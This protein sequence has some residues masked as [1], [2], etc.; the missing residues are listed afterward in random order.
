MVVYIEYIFLD[1]I[2]INIF[3]LYTT[4]LVQRMKPNWLAIFGSG[5][6]GAI[7]SCLYPFLSFYNYIV[8]V[9]L[10]II[11][12][13][14][15]KKYKTIKSFFS[16]LITFYFI[17]F[18]LAG[19]VLMISSFNIINLENYYGIVQLFPFCI[20][21]SCTI[22]IILIKLCIKDFYKNRNLQKLLYDVLIETNGKKIKLKGYYDSGNQLYDPKTNKPMVI[23]SDSIYNKL[24]GG[25][26]SEIEIRTIGGIK[27][28]KTINMS[29]LIYFQD[30]DNKIYRTSAGISNNFSKEYDL[31]LHRDMT[32]E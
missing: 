22:L 26:E 8:K 14:I 23:I 10:G 28:I 13:V 24:K 9:L 1:N 29:L 30:K 5:S 32:G 2:A 17:T 11:M 16:T 27:T 25:E 18:S 12:I 31:I 4:L 3:I 19:I 20:I 6:I 15:L 7:F 21:S